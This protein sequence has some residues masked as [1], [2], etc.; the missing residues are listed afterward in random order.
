MILVS[1]FL[2]NIELDN[3]I[4]GM[5]RST[6]QADGSETIEQ[7]TGQY[8]FDPQR[9]EVYL[10]RLEVLQDRTYHLKF[11]GFWRYVFDCIC[12]LPTW[13]DI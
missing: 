7:P 1:T 12:P 10:N 8:S 11:G 3:Q 9:V 13:I 5:D 2:Q 4:W 6:K